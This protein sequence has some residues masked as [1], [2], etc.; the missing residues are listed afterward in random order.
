[1]PPEFLVFCSH[2]NIINYPV[3]LSNL[4]NSGWAVEP[5]RLVDDL[6]RSSYSRPTDAYT[7]IGRPYVLGQVT[8]EFPVFA[9]S[10]VP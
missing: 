2:Q 7:L 1:M 10:R 8:Q 9:E 5:A 4:P 6:F 3:R